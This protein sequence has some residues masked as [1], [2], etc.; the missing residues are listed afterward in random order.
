ML[1][2]YVG[3]GPWE[4]FGWYAGTGPWERNDC[5]CVLTESVLYEVIHIE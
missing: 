3:T 4:R 1:N 2:Q 5:L